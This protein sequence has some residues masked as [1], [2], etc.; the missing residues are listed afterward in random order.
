[1][2]RNVLGNF[3]AHQSELFKILIEEYGYGMH[4]KKHSTIFEEMMRQAGLNATTHHYWQFYTAPSMALTNYFHYIS[5]NHQHF[6]RYLGALFTIR[7]RASRM[8]RRPS[9]ARSGSHS[10]TNSIPCI[11][12]NTRI[13]TFTMGVWRSS[14]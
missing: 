4:E 3:S 13:S 9:R 5:A 8:R 12:M 10:A 14:D 6:F 11:S 2:A 1:M 7:K